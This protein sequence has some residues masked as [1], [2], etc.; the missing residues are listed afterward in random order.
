MREWKQFCFYFAPS[1]PYNARVE[2]VVL[3]PSELENYSNTD[4]IICPGV[5]ELG[6]SMKPL[7]QL[8]S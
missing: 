2:A 7:A 1:S 3:L 6:S 4:Y 8:A 5:Q